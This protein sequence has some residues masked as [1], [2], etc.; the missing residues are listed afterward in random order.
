MGDISMYKTSQPAPT[1]P[2]QP[3]YSC[4]GIGFKA[5]INAPRAAMHETV[6]HGTPDSAVRGVV[7]VVAHYEVLSRR[8][9]Y[10]SPCLGNRTWPLCRQLHPGLILCDTIAKQGVSLHPQ[11]VARQ[12]HDAFDEYHVGLG[13]PVEDQQFVELRVAPAGKSQVPEGQP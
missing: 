8:H 13:R 11:S 2:A 12:S 5:V 1:D 6:R 3:R 9:D 10:G 4:R 7:S